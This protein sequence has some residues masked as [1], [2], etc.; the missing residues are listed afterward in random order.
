MLSSICRAPIELLLRDGPWRSANILKSSFHTTHV[1]DTRSAGR[2]KPTIKRDKP[3]TYEE[4]WKPDMIG[5]RK[6]WNS[7]S[8]SGLLDGLRTAETSHEDIL[9]RK[10]LHGTW[11]KLL[12]SDVIIKRRGNQIYCS[13]VAIRAI[14]PTQMYFLIGYSEEILSYLLKCVVKLEVQTVE[15]ASD[16]TYKYI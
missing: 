1:L 15:E 2:H 7:F 14:Y 8:T 5:V 13:F 16:M 9:L 12:A 11:P 4:S 3:L 6:S 10:F